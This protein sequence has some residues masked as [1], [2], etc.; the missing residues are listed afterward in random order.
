LKVAVTGATGTIGR[1]VVGALLERGDE[2][3]VLSR[4]AGRARELLGGVQ[5]FAWP[6]VKGSPA[7]AEALAGCDAVVNLLGEHVAQRWS[8]SARREIRDSRV[9]GTRNLVAGLRAADPRPR[10][11]VSQSGCDYYGARGDERVEESAQNGDGFLAGVTVDWEASARE[12]EEV[13]VRVVTTRTGV[14]LSE[15]G[16]ALAKMLPFFKAGV[17]GPVAGGRQWVPWIHVDDVVG[18]ML[19]CLDARGASGPVNLGAPEP[20]RNAELSKALGR[21]LGR[22]AVLPVPALA[23][24]LLYGDMASIVTG[25]V[26]M[27]PARLAE[28][29]YEFRRTDLEDALRAATGR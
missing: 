6:D 2:V 19:H 5:T 25:G 15:E 17:G 3:S 9:L 1:R 13:G 20:V 24:R 4:D 26:R 14:V 11:L 7:P 10:V 23:L 27:V 21:V 12:A 16:G 22:P 8:D 18:A 29:G 28:L